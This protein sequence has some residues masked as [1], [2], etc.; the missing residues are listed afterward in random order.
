MIEVIAERSKQISER[1]IGSF[2]ESPYNN[3]EGDVEAITIKEP[4]ES[5]DNL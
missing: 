1:D 3:V 5:I 4:E 2:E